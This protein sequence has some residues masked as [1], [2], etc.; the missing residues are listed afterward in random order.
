MSEEPSTS[1]RISVAVTGRRSAIRY[2]I[3]ESCRISFS[4][5]FATGR[6][7]VRPG[8]MATRTR[9]RFA[10][11]CA[12][13]LRRLTVGEVGAAAEGAVERRPLAALGELLL[14]PVE[15]PEPAAEVVDH[16]HERGLSRARD[17]GR[18]VL[19]RPVVGKDDVEHRA[20]EVLGEA[21]QLL[22][23]AADPVIAER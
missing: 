11:I 7:V 2:E 4:V 3:S 22:D 1:R 15:R 8:V 5:S 13:L 19:E 12:V 16:V 10:P 14:E 20:G 6:T 18:A 9:V 21:G 23:Q 17:P